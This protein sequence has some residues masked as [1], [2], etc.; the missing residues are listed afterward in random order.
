MLLA[1]I[2]CL[3]TLQKG[4]INDAS[5]PSTATAH[6][7]RVLFSKMRSTTL[8]AH[9]VVVG[10]THDGGYYLV[11]AKSFHPTLFASDG[12]GTSSALE[13]SIARTSS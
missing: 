4:F 13:T 11:G 10:P 3:R 6:T 8:T 7:C 1:S 2:R 9:D 5:L 12:M